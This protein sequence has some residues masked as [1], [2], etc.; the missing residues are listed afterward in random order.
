[1]VFGI[2]IEKGMARFQKEVEDSEKMECNLDR[3]GSSLAV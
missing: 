1:M 2:Y 3:G